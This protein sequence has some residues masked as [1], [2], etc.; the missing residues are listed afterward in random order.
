MR[1]QIASMQARRREAALKYQRDQREQNEAHTQ[2]F[3][4]KPPEIIKKKSTPIRSI[5][6]PRSPVSKGASP[7]S[8]EKM[9]TK[10]NQRGEE[11]GS[12]NE[13][14]DDEKKDDLEGMLAVSSP[15]ATDASTQN[16]PTKNEEAAQSPISN[17]HS[18]P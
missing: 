13:K 17:S 1:E 12:K 6:S 7:V 15:E 10:S 14:L 16:D 4:T 8:P 5:P 3:T 9:F 18:S 2:A 11:S